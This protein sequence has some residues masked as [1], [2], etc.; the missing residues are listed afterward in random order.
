M[1]TRFIPAY[2]KEVV[3]LTDEQV[4]SLPEKVSIAG[5]IQFTKSVKA[6]ATQLKTN[7]KELN[8]LTGKHSKEV[9]QVLGCDVIALSSMKKV[10]QGRAVLFIG[11]GL[12]HPK[13][14]LLANPTREVYL[15]NPYTR[16]LTKLDSREVNSLEKKKRAGLTKFL[17]STQIGVLY[18][19]KWGQRPHQ[20]LDPIY[21]AYPEKRFYRFLADT[22]DFNELENF[23]YIECWVNTACPRIAYDD[24]VRVPK[25]MVDYTTILALL[26]EEQK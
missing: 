8:F 18:S 14:L 13:A 5:T 24:T 10:E 7:G 3:T 26:N 6:I 17:V 15:F 9:G 4:A 11:D 23:T 25:P 12:F 1:D 21:R 19:M 16:E 2:A 22:I 20:S